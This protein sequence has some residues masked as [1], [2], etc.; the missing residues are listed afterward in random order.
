MITFSFIT[1]HI[2]WLR[3]TYV[4]KVFDHKLDRTR[5]TQITVY[6]QLLLMFSKITCLVRELSHNAVVFDLILNVK[7]RV[8][9]QHN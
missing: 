2:S 1:L 9:L 7:I 5:S 3:A 4:A 8:S 6:F